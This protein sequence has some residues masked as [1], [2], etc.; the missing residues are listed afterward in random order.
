MSSTKVTKETKL[1]IEKSKV[2][3]TEIHEWNME[4]RTNNVCMDE[5]NADVRMKKV[6]EIEKDEAQGRQDRD[7]ANAE[8]ERT[9][10]ERENT[11]V[12][13]E[14]ANEDREWTNNIRE[15]ACDER[16]CSNKDREMANDKRERTKDEIVHGRRKSNKI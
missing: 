12:A 2:G 13:R 1:E 6:G 7:R 11:I 16:E 15:L 9:I 4:L 5:H 8:R 3:S 14:R 10:L